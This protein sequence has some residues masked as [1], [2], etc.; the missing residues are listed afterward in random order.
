MEILGIEEITV[1]DSPC[2]LCRKENAT[3]RLALQI[4]RAVIKLV[5]CDKCAT[6]PADEIMK[7]I[8]D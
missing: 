1:Q 5:V 4:K 8:R 7:I 6:M 2:M 3:G